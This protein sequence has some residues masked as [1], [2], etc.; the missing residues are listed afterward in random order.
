MQ[1]LCNFTELSKEDAAL[2]GGKG[3]SL[4]EMT[5]AEI[6]V[7]SGF[8]ILTQ[9][10]EYFLEQIDLNVEIA[11]ILET[12]DH[13]KMHTVENASEKIQALILSAKM[14]TA[15]SEEI[16]KHFSNL[17]A[18]F[19]A[20]RSSATAEDSSV[21]AWAGQLDTYLNTTSEE[22]LLNVQKCWGSLFTPRAIFY[23][24]EK[25]LHKQKISVAV[26]VQKMIDSE[27]SG[28]AFSVHPVTQDYNQLIIEAGLGLGEAIVSGQVTP[29]SYVVQKSNLEIL[30]KNIA[31]Q[32]RFLQKKE[33]GGNDW[34]AVPYSK[35]KIQKLSDKDVI[36]LS[37]LVIQIEKHYG[38]P[39]DVE[40][41]YEKGKFYITQSRPITTLTKSN[42]KQNNSKINL[43]DRKWVVYGASGWPAYITPFAVA[44]AQNFFEKYR[45]SN[46]G[47]ALWQGK[48]FDW[49]YDEKQLIDISK[50]VLPKLK[51][52]KW[53]YYK[54][55]KKSAK[56]FDAFH[57]K[58]MGVDLKKLNEQQF[59]KL[60]KQYYKAFL[61]QYSISN[62]I[63]PL[64]FYLQGHLGRL[65]EVEGIDPDKAKQLI[66]QFGTSREP[67]YLKLCVQEYRKS[68]RKIKSI[69]KKYHYINND[70]T[71][72]RPFIEADLKDLVKKNG[73]HDAK[74]VKAK[75]SPRVKTLLQI[76]Q[77]TATIQDVRKAESL[78]WVSGAEKILHE[79]SFRTGVAFEELLYASWN[80][81]MENKID[82]LE[83]KK[84][85]PD[86]VFHWHSKGETI[87]VNKE[88][89]AIKEEYKKVIVGTTDNLKELKGVP[90]SSGIAKGKAVVV[91][92]VSQFAKVKEGDI[93]ITVMTRPEYLPV[94]HLAA[95]FVTDEGGITSHAAIVAREMKKPCVIG[96]KIGSKVIKDGDL[97]EV[98]ANTG[99]VKIIERV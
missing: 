74:E 90:A 31:E 95:A 86:V 52:Q 94:M 33:K 80:E 49:L 99:V 8:V 83:L 55:W 22:L 40:W 85:I 5:R 6:P 14:P 18:S 51:R 88:A 53:D 89:E 92:N 1:L 98:D 42:V 26:V 71:G 23:R 68:P 59:V 32:I 81:L 46:E 75:V 12:V 41:A 67:N 36:E 69:L 20:V 24:F 30:D 21:A 87:Y 58:L 62:I 15:I 54:K 45:I 50:K 28:I 37:N 16:N 66:G 9:A 91:F 93:L 78:M 48:N 11:A 7:P 3:A 10:F 27:V 84:R 65:L 34:V 17:G 70:Y 56:M 19:V 79:L 47:I 57:Y 76:L 13:T 97:L 38:F 73:N 77:L 64:S 43:E 35:R 29:D 60:L 82:T 4:G 25:E 96:T 2:A 61:D 44:P 72:T 63:E 39:C